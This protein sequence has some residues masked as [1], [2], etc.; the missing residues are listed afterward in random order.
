MANSAI[1]RVGEFLAPILQGIHERT[2][3]HVLALLGGPV[4]K[5]G[6]QL[7]TVQCVFQ[8]R[9]DVKPGPTLILLRSV[10]FGRNKTAA[11]AHFPVWA[12]DRFV[13]VINL[14]KEYLNTVFGKY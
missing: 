4:P 2:G 6:G 14:M 11:G 10:S 7:R 9:C 1:D 3:M 8:C 13:P 5:Y 12:N